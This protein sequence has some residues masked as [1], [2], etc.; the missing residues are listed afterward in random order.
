M[1]LENLDWDFI[2]GVVFLVIPVLIGVF[3]LQ[4]HCYYL[5]IK[6][7]DSLEKSLKPGD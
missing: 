4:Y 2:Y 1:K 7:L 3:W 6:K 5:Q